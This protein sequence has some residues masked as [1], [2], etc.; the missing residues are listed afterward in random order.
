MMLEDEGCC[1]DYLYN[2]GRIDLAR[3][4]FEENRGKFRRL[5]IKK[6]IV[7]CAGCYHTFNTWYPELL[8]GKDFE[9]IHISQLLPDLLRERKEALE[10]VE[11]GMVYQDACGL[12]RLEG[13]YDEPREA[14]QL[15]GVKLAEVGKNK[16]QADCCAAKNISNFRDLS[17][18]IASSFLDKVETPNIVTSCPFC[19]FG[20]NYACRKTGKDKRLLYLS[21]VVLDSLSHL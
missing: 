2:I 11:R 8:G 19:L 18:K 21:E 13:I 7:L 12:G 9:V 20:L 1:G 15:C 17:I 5:G 3:E 6:V 4:K 16:E 10:Q 14:L